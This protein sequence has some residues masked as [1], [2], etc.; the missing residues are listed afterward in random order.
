VDLSERTLKEVYF[1]PY[2][3]TIDAGVATVMTSFNDLNGIPASCNPWLLTDVLRREWGFKGFIVSDYTSI[4]E[5]VPHGIA[6][7]DKMAGELAFKAGLDMDM[8]GAVY[9]RFLKQSLEEGKTT[10]D[11]IDTSVRRILL[12]KFELG[13]FDDPFRYLDTARE[14][15]IILSQEMKDFAYEIGKASIVLLKN[16]QGVL[17]ISQ[18]NKKIALVGPLA[19]DPLNMLGSWHASGNAADAVSVKAAFEQQD[20]INWV[21]AQGCAIEGTDQT[22]FGEAIT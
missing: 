6:A 22:L 5:L 3:A 11:Q 12:M 10:I 9:Y 14:K 7:D 4:N 13:L 20:G 15:E 1:P 18:E 8:Q 19:D 21:Y 17:P 2:Q 16:E